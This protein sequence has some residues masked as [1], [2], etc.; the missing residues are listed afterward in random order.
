MLLHLIICTTVLWGGLQRG[1]FGD[2]EPGGFLSV[3]NVAVCKGFLY[4]NKVLLRV[5]KT[6][7][8]KH[9]VYLLSK[10]R[11]MDTLAKLPS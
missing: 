8:E 11:S 2:A 3:I 6:I 10:S 7:E 4:E 9:P 5:Q 1:V